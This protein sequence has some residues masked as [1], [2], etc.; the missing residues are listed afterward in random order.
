MS[1]ANVYANANR[2]RGMSRRELTDEQRFHGLVEYAR[3]F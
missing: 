1:P 2:C 3:S